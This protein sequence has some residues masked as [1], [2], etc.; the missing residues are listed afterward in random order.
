[1]KITVTEDFRMSRSQRLLYI[2]ESSLT[3]FYTKHEIHISLDATNQK[4]PCR[5]TRNLVSMY[6]MKTTFLE[7]EGPQVG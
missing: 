7:A 5:L 6:R 3:N 4:Q 2:M 1:M